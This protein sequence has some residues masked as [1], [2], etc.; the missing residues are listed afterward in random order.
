MKSLS[1]RRIVPACVLSAAAVAAFA[2]AGTANAA[3]LAPCTGTSPQEAAGSSLQAVAQQ[4]VWNV[5]FNTSKAKDACSK[6]PNKPEV[7]YISTSSGKGYAA[8]DTSHLFKQDGF[9]G[10][11]NT[12]N[13]TEK[14][15][16]EG[17]ADG[18]GTFGMGEGVLTIPVAQSAVAIIINLG[19]NCTANST[20]A[21]GRL[22]LTQK[23]LEGIYAGTITE[24][25]KITEDGDQLIGGANCPTTISPVVRK[26]ASGT[27]H[28]FKRFLNWTEKAKFKFSGSKTLDWNEASELENSTVWPEALGSPVEG[29]KSSGLIAK[30]QETPG[31]IGYV[32]LPEARESGFDTA[33]EFWAELESGNKKG[34]VTY[35]D[36]SDDKDIATLSNS[37]CAKTVYTNEGGSFPPPSVTKNWNEVSASQ[38]SKTYALCGLTYDLALI[39]YAAYET[40]YGTTQGE[41]TT[42]ENYLAYVTEKKG[43]QKEIAGHDYLALP[44]AVRV[45]AEQGVKLITWEP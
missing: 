13:P 22:A 15:A 24:W 37:N 25:S 18:P 41:A 16:L 21:P 32:N 26:D 4:Q 35:A 38:Y 36:P 44:N 6:A 29:E 28:I 33:N 1:V 3:L 8:W 2:G 39:N 31:R 5:K 9:I 40:T 27:T 45:K 10:T 42:V 43:G 19:P 23:T 11:D 14:A 30:V 20:A 34:K 12:V 7:K 17:L